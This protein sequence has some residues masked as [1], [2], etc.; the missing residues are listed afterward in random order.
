MAS[1]LAITTSP[2]QTGRDGQAIDLVL[3]VV[4]AIGEIQGS[5]VGTPPPGVF[6]SGGGIAGAVH[7]EWPFPAIGTWEVTVT[8]DD[9]DI[10]P[11]TDTE[12]FTFT[13]YPKPTSSI[14]LEAMGVKQMLGDP[15][16]QAPSIRQIV[17]ELE[18]EYQHITN[19]VNNRGQ[20]QHIGE[21]VITTVENQTRYVLDVP[22]QDFFKALSMTSIPA[23]A[24]VTGG[25]H[26]YRVEVTSGDDHE[27]ILEFFELEHGAFE[28]AY[29]AKNRGQV[30]SS[31]HDSQLVGFYKTLVD[32]EGE[33]LVLEMRPTPARAQRYRLLYQITD[34]WDRV[35]A[36]PNAGVNDIEFRLPHSS[37][38]MMIRAT[39]GMNLI[40]K[41]VVKWALNDEYNA[42]RGQ[43]VLQGLKDRFDRYSTAF[44]EYLDTLEHEDVVFI[45]LWADRL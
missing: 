2:T 14:I 27:N 16:D 42:K 17:L 37:Q 45:E 18:A 29:M 19:I 25:E 13:I 21:L 1:P 35:F 43:V 28:W 31:S 10:P 32:G 8:I 11:N 36:S 33:K 22:S 24:T 12:T 23:S 7:I 30:L 40:Q 15:L 3:T 44:N 20:A 6:L 9:Q 4:D 34:W 39:V 26:D 5:F 41:G 38:R